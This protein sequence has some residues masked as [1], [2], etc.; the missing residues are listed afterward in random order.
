MT[1]HM[2]S[3]N[4]QYQ[5]QIDYIVCSWRWRSSI[6]SAKTRP[7]TDC[8]LDN[9]LLIAKFR[10]TLKKVGKTTRPVRYDLNQTPYDYTVEVK[11]LPDLI[12]GLDLVEC[13]KNYR[14]VRDIV[15]EALTKTIPKEMKC[16]KAKWLYEEALQIAEERRE[17]EN[18][19]KGKGIPNWMQSSKEYQGKTT[20]PSSINN[21]KINR[22]KQQNGKD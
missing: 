12:K 9:Q 20:R 18:R 1:L 19:M 8:G 13:L 14:Q 10:R 17:A 16:K 4:G 15:Q 2:T 22:G 5:N 3:P 21:S 6:Q 11:N 7:G